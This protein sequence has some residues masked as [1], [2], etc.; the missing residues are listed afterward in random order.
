MKEFAIRPGQLT[1][2]VHDGLVAAI[3]GNGAG[4]AAT[5]S[6]SDLYDTSLLPFYAETIHLVE[7]LEA[8]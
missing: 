1:I 2:E 5:H 8:C 6:D 4:G 7:S 3:P